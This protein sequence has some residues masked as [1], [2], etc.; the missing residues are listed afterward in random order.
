MP[1]D[2]RDLEKR[3]AATSPRDT[4]RGVAFNTAFEVIREH[5][6]DDL[7]KRCDPARTG[8]RVD[9]FAY[10]VSDF[11]KMAWAAADALES[12]LGGIDG[13]FYA[14]GHRTAKGILESALGKTLTTIAGTNP[15][16]LLSSAPSGYR[17]VVSYGERAVQWKGEKHA[18]FVFKRD[19]LVPSYHCGILAG[20]VESLGAKNVKAVGTETA[21]LDT[22]YE[23]TWD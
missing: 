7:V 20:G 6:G 3:L 18:H 23:V 21:F 9:F 14:L 11:L 5:G 8:S 2:R 15:R 10:P 12:K 16:A 4:S 22:S 1:A 17:T 13:V 19:F